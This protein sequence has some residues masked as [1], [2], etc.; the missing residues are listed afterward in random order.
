MDSESKID[1]QI[2][3]LRE[4]NLK[5]IIYIPYIYRFV[6]LYIQ[7]YSNSFY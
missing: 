5:K 3:H 1:L 2:H 4:Y 6:Q 7:Q